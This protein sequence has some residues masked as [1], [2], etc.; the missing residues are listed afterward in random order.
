MNRPKKILITGSN[1]F[2]GKALYEELKNL[3]YKLIGSVRDISKRDSSQLNVIVGSIDGKTNWETALDGCSVVIHLAGRAHILND[4]SE[5]PYSDFYSINTEGTIN[6]AKQSIKKGVKRFIFVSSIGVNG[7]K[8]GETAITAKT[9][10]NPNSPYAKSK[11]E[12]E[13]ALQQMSS[14]NNMEL[15]IVRP[16]AIYGKDAPG[17]FGLIE[18]FLK[19]GIPLPFGSI[20]NKRSLIYL[21]NL[22]SFLAVCVENKYLADR[23]LVVDDNE[24]LSTSEIVLLIACL[25]NSRARIINFPKFILSFLLKTIGKNKM[26]ESLMNN[27]KIDSSVPRDITGWEPPFNPKKLLLKSNLIKK[28][29]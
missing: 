19:K 9:A 2:V 8:S 13:I 14:K 25:S 22:T 7:S 21:H 4:K 17:N 29:I 23:V 16:P 26:K 11:I 5:D 24:D 12:A 28:N 18:K 3:D 20:K 1:G 6:L 10:I 15:V 27:L